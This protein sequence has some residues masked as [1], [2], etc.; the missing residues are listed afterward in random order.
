M[1]ELHSIITVLHT[2]I[3]DNSDVLFN[4]L[5]DRFTNAASDLTVI[6]NISHHLYHL[7]VRV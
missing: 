4:I 6:E 7:R 1:S 2:L 5:K 3:N